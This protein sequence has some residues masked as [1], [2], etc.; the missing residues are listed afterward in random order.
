M[1]L[2]VLIYLRRA[3]Q[4]LMLYRNKK[5]NDLNAGK[6]IGVGGKI[7]SGES[8]YEAI[9]RETREETDYVL[10]SARFVGVVT[11]IDHREKDYEEMMFMFTSTDF[12]GEMKT[13][14]EGDLHWIDDERIFD[15]PM[16]EADPYYLAWL[17]DDDVHLAKA[18]YADG[19]L[20]NYHEELKKV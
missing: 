16:W 12:S 19:R 13:C 4:T 1:V 20:V 3:H 17:N 18:E 2:S 6:W 10:H 15:L 7:E 14:N 8:P 11:F 5:K 9:V